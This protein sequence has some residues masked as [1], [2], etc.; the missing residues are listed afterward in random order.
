[1][2]PR[3]SDRRRRHRRPTQGEREPRSARRFPARPPARR[4]GEL[5]GARSAKPRP[6]PSPLARRTGRP[7]PAHTVVAVA[8]LF[9]GPMGSP[10]PLFSGSLPSILLRRG[11][12]RVFELSG[13]NEEDL[14]A[15]SRRSTHSERGE[16]LR[17]LLPLPVSLSFSPPFLYRPRP[18]ASPL[19]NAS[20]SF[21]SP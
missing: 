14:R 21:P 11:V 4:G 18:A 5:V 19:L 7:P 1:M 16:G 13:K 9:S 12:Q 2:I 15:P 10:L 8:F 17:R 6:T 3:P 20:V